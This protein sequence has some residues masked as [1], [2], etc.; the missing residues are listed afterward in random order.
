M[1][2]SPELQHYK[3]QRLATYARLDSTRVS[4]D[5][6]LVAHENCEPPAADIAN[7]A[8]LLSFRRILLTSLDVLDEQFLDYLLRLKARQAAVSAP[9]PDNTENTKAVGKRPARKAV[10]R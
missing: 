3:S 2:Q 6:W 4:I 8:G 7:L 10:R 9:A 5:D 1:M